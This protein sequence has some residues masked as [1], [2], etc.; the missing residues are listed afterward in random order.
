MMMYKPKYFDESETYCKCGCG[1]GGFQVMDERVLWLADIIRIE[2][3]FPLVVNSAIRCPR[4]NAAEVKGELRSFHLRGQA[5]DFRP[6]KGPEFPK[7]LKKL[8]E[9]SDRLNP[10]GGVGRYDH[11]VHIDTGPKRRWRK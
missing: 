6:C 8:R 11:F 1:L 2:C 5:I 3:G 9:V 4:H 7:Q 10:K